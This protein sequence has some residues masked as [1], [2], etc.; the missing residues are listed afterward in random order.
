MERKNWP[1]TK[2]PL[3]ENIENL[4]AGE[5]VAALTKLNPVKYNYKVDKTDKHV[6]FIA[7]DVPELAATSDRK[8]LSPMDVTAVLTKV[9]QEQQNVIQEYRKLISDLQKRMATLEKK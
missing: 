7:E 4:N 5:A 9:A 3:K 2:S 6:G 1:G 8:G